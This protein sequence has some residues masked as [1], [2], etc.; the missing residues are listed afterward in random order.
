[1]S[2]DSNL[3]VKKIIL[4][5]DKI[6]S[7]LEYPFNIDIV[8]NFEIDLAILM[9]NIQSFGNSSLKLNKFLKYLMIVRKYDNLIEIYYINKKFMSN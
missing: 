4:K 2:I 1:M 8:K 7:F 6:E 3:L 9:D 5:R